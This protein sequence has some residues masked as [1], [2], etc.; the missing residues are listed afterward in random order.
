MSIC[1]A[2]SRL[3]YRNLSISTLLFWASTTCVL[4][5]TRTERADPTS[6][7][8]DGTISTAY[9]QL[10]LAVEHCCHHCSSLTLAPAF[11]PFV[12]S[13]YETLCHG[14]PNHR[15][16]G[17]RFQK[18]GSA[19]GRQQGGADAHHQKA[20]GGLSSA[21][22]E[23]QGRWRIFLTE[24]HGNTRGDCTQNVDSVCPLFLITNIQGFEDAVAAGATEVA[25]FGAASEAF[26]QKNINCR[27]A[28]LAFC[29]VTPVHSFV[30]TIDGREMLGD[31]D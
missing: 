1:S 15:G 29:C 23:S 22:A 5:L 13:L 18:V 19:N 7:T 31:K 4:P 6:A 24:I 10:L 14:P 9:R 17:L 26:S 21:H 11:P 12:H 25:L 8:T 3:P 2:I 28:R 20:R 30:R 27:Y 16:H